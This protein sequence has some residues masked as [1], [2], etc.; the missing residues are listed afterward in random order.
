[1]E[2]AVFDHGGTLDKFL[3]DG[4]M[5][6]FGTPHVGP[7]DAVNALGC[8][9]AMLGAIDAWNAEWARTGEPGIRLSVG[10]HYGEVVIGDVGSKRRLELAVLGDTVNVGYRLEQLTRDL[11]CR[12]VVSDEEVRAARTQAGAEAEPLLSGFGMATPQ[13]IHGRDGPVVVWCLAG[14]DA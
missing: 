12:M 1:M 11:G 13:A 9:R 3:G 2:L 6:T 5:A 8:A 7:C 10:I 14:D 4:V